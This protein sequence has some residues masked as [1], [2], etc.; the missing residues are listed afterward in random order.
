MKNLWCG[1]L[2]G[3]GLARRTLARTAI[4]VFGVLAVL[5]LALILG[6]PMA[7]AQT[8]DRGRISGTVADQTG[9]VIP[10]ANVALRNDASGAEFKTT[11]DTKGL[12]VYDY[13]LPAT[14][15][16]TVSSAGFKTFVQTNLTLHPGS[17]LVIDAALQVGT[18]VETVEVKGTAVNLI[19]KS[20]AALTPTIEAA[21]IQNESTIGRDALELLTLL[22]GVVGGT[23]APGANQNGGFSG[24]SGTGFQT[25]GGV[26][27]EAINGFN[28]NGLRNDQNMI[29]LDNSYVMDPGENGGFVVEPNM[30]MIQEF[31]VKTSGFEASQGTGGI[32]VDAVTKSGGSK[33]HGEGYYYARNAVFNANDWS[34]NQ[35][36][37]PKPNSKFNYPGFNIGGPVR[38]PG[39]SFNKN[40]DKMFF[41]YGVEWQRQ[42]ADP[43]TNLRTVPTQAMR[44]GDF[45]GLWTASNSTCTKNGSGVVTGGTFLGI[46]CILNDPATG[47]PTVGNILPANEVTPDGQTI[48]NES[49]VLPNYVDPTGGTDLAAH[50]L[51]PTNRIENNIRIDYNLTQNT[52]AFLR[53]AQNSDH[54][55][56]PYGIWA[57]GSGW[58]GSVPRV[59]PIVGHDS[60]ESA[61]INVVQVINPTLTNEIQFSM[62][63]I[64][65]PYKYADPTKVSSSQLLNDLKGFNWAKA[66]G[67]SVYTRTVEVPQIWDSITAGGGPGGGG[68]GTWGPGDEYNGIYG[69][70]TVFEFNDNLTKVMATHTLQFGFAL[71][72]T[73]N[74]QNQANVEGSIW[75]TTWGDPNSSG[76]TFADLLAQDFM[77]WDQATNDPDGMWRFWN[78][79]WYAQDSWKV[80]RK[81]TL[82][83]GARFAY[84]PPWV[85]ARGAVST[86][87]PAL[88]TAANDSSINDGVEVGSGIKAVESAA[89]F[90]QSQVGTY[91]T[92]LPSSG[93]FPNPSVFV[94]PRVGVAY[95]MLGNG[96][97]VLRVGA[98]I[99]TERDQGN[100]VFGFAQNPPFEF[101]ANAV[102]STSLANGGF[103][104]TQNPNPYSGAG[105]ISATVADQSD[106]HIPQS[107]QWNFT[108]DQDIGWK[109][110]LEA[111]Y[112]GN[113]S[114]HLYVENQ[115][116]AIPL[117][118]LFAPGT[119]T[120]LPGASSCASGG[121]SFRYYQPFGALDILHHVT[122]SN[123]NSLQVTARR[124]VT[125][126]LTLLASYT[127]SKTLGYSGAFN[128]TVDPFNSRLNYGL[129][130]YDRPQLFN[131]SYIYQLPNAGTKY[132]NGNK[133][134]GGVLNGWQLSGITS[135]QSGAPLAVGFGSP[136]LTCSGNSTVCGSTVFQGNGTGWYG[137]D[138]RTLNPLLLSNAQK[139][140]G[141]TQVGSDWLNP[142]AVTVPAVNQPGTYEMPQMLGPG[143]NNFDVTLF[144]S[145]KIAEHQRLEFRVAAFDIFNRAQLDNPI[146]GANIV[147]NVPATATAV[148]QGSPSAVTNVPASGAPCNSTE[149]GCIA[150]KHGHREMEFA[151]K[152]YF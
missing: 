27:T 14:Y 76:N 8:A 26:S 49:W 38:F 64:N 41:F 85:E 30:D 58:G 80:N 119:T 47:K 75:T 44:T 16:L 129:Q 120:L 1:E 94:S 96:K 139:G 128:G 19:P 34:N 107:Y 150:D 121:C 37:I 55:Y 22:P 132:F 124:N 66:T 99:Y 28:V 109:T 123:Y 33:V 40:N 18:K 144:K 141:F 138:A 72:R 42:L 143:S 146:T 29:K 110:I 71:N 23:G 98:G 12:Y 78:W 74:D 68:A 147:W 113:T 3:V 86:F 142:S 93:G 83:Y 133:I 111:G 88:W 89:Y 9:A 36:G 118:G 48:L 117:G 25:V 11:T 15:T 63:Q 105:S 102:L 87:N 77:R 100:T 57:G 32:I 101:S 62:N 43:G 127:Y 90:P 4:R 79:E 131:I 91:A 134:A 151:I 149:F 60:G 84:T 97:T 10:G 103:A 130:S 126:G 104:E 53:L 13:I 135:F 59:S 21:Q 65:Y 2:V 112:V 35:A 52:R 6:S 125:Q 106:K 7:C 5:G 50:P 45:S 108:I 114:R 67:G 148:S 152:L 73:R 145:F 24:S 54:E 95:D 31:S 20:T 82:N 122:T 116:G 136:G 51:Y 115:I 39:T 70:K 17:A 56:Y 137:T 69:N 81:L 61:T 140:A 92:G 46:N